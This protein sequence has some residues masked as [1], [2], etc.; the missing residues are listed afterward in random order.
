MFATDLQ[1]KGK[2]SDVEKVNQ[3]SL[4]V[5]REELATTSNISNGNTKSHLTNQCEC[6]KRNEKFQWG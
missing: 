3:S 1:T 6:E 2:E 4:A 5:D